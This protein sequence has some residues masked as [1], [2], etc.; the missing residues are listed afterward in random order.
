MPS[1]SAQSKCIGLSSTHAEPVA[2]CGPVPLKLVLFHPIPPN[3]ASTCNI[4]AIVSPQNDN[5]GYRD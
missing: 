1:N 2:L 5:V 3:F 4:V